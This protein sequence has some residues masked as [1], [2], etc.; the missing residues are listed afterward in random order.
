MQVY[1]W[2]HCLLQKRSWVLIVSARLPH[3]RP[4]GNLSVLAYIHLSALK[5]A[6]MH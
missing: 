6:V 2:I 3:N 4:L 1:T 5:P